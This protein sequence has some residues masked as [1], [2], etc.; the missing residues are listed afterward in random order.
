MTFWYYLKKVIFIALAVNTVL[1]LI[2]SAFADTIPSLT[3]GFFKLENVIFILLFSFIASA[4]TLILYLKRIGLFL[5]ILIHYGLLTVM[6]FLFVVVFGNFAGEAE[7]RSS[8]IFLA[9]VIYTLL[10]VVFAIGISVV[11]RMIT[12]KNAAKNDE[13]ESQF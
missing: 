6:I 9:F 10:Y 4:I 5:R 1:I 3:K 8:V 7:S 2:V 11:N 13:Y 12:K